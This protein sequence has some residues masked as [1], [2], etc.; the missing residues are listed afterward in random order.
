[1]LRAYQASGPSQVKRDITTGLHEHK[2]LMIFL[3]D[4][5][6]VARKRHMEPNTFATLGARIFSQAGIL[7]TE[8]TP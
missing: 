2:V 7:Y 6:G 4:A 3:P 5:L 8:A 1:M